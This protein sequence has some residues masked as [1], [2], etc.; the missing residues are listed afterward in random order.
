[1]TN[2]AHT[3]ESVTLAPTAVVP[4]AVSLIRRHSDNQSRVPRLSMT[5]RM[6]LAAH[7]WSS[8]AAEL[9]ACIQQ[10]LVLCNGEIIEA[11][12]L[13][14]ARGNAQRVQS[15]VL[16]TLRAVNGVRS[17]AAKRLGINTSTL[18]RQ[19]AGMR[20]QGFVVPETAPAITELSHE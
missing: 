18:R 1:M 15:R 8:D 7:E 14:L 10:A 3:I 12:D 20:A 19:L 13:R 4:A 17:E 11:E 5:A 9:D 6:S 2:T 16:R